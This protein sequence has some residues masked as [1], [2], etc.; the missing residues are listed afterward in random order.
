V[1]LLSKRCKCFVLSFFVVDFLCIISDEHDSRYQESSMRQRQIP[2][3]AV[4]GSTE[5]K[6]SGLAVGRVSGTPIQSSQSF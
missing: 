2:D 6:R 4:K 5:D 1:S 3:A